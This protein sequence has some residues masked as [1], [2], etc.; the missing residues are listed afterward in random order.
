MTKEEK[1]LIAAEDEFFNKGFDATSTAAIA[2]KVGVTHAMVNYYFR[3][4]EQL[5]IK[6]LD[7]NV[8]A[9]IDKI[10]P[11]MNPGGTVA[12]VAVHAAEVLFDSLNTRREFPFIIQDLSRTH[13]DFLV[14]YW[15]EV[16]TFFTESIKK[17]SQM[18]SE[19]IHD[20]A[21][22]QCTM[23]DIYDTIFTLA[24][25]PFL[26]IPLLRNVAGMDDCQINLYLESH[27]KEMLRIIKSRYSASAEGKNNS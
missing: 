4:K 21:M 23:N 25:S 18:L 3:T 6:V 15:K 27:R 16:E 12:D 7:N 1:I 22:A 24:V 26:H 14:Q 17:H 9:L 11:L 8:H 13:P 20:G 19:Q 10:M 5:F 2:K